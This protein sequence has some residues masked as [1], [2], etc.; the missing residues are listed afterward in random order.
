MYFLNSVNSAAE[1][2]ILEPLMEVALK[3]P[4][5]FQGA[6]TGDINKRKGM[7]V[8]NDQDGDGTVVV[9]HVCAKISFSCSFRFHNEQL[10]T[11]RNTCTRIEVH[12]EILMVFHQI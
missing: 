10:I 4:S 5:E 6:I 8:G 7:I 1:P 11:T 9:A 2:V 3:V 12:L